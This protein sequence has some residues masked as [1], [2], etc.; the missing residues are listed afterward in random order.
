[1]LGIILLVLKNT[2]EVLN[3]STAGWWT[4]PTDEDPFSTS[5][6]ANTASPPL[7]STGHIKSFSDAPAGV[8][9]DIHPNP[10]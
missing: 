5:D 1:V 6:L 10:Q 4:S 9:H 7:N 2:L 8:G 3:T